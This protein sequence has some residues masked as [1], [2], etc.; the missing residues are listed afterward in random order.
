MTGSV[1]AGGDVSGNT[2]AEGPGR[3]VETLQRVPQT[4]HWSQGAGN[5]RGGD[6]GLLAECLHQALSLQTLTKMSKGAN[7][8][9]NET[10]RL[11]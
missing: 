5:G 9:S 7:I 4:S 6:Q 11:T 1:F 10:G 3:H 2:E 8:N